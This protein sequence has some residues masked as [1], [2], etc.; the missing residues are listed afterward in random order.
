M[1]VSRALI[2]GLG[3]VAPAALAQPAVS[4]TPPGAAQAQ[5]D[6]VE[7]HIAD[8]K[9]RLQITP[10]QE[11]QWS[12]FASVMR[13]NGKRMAALYDKRAANQAGV[14]ATDDLHNYAEL[15]RAHSEDMQRLVPAFDAL[16]AVMPPAQQGLADKLFQEF[17][18][19]RRVK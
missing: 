5:P 8:M 12:G 17:Q 7:K 2:I 10:A 11:P 6:R 1:K 19:R 13:E 15:T 16:Y 14:K 9:R 18:T 3:L 4:G